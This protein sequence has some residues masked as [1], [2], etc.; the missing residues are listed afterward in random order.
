MTLDTE[1]KGNRKFLSTVI[2]FAVSLTI[3][4]VIYILSIL[5]KNWAM[6]DLIPHEY[7][8]DFVAILPGPLWTDTILLYLFPL[9]IYGLFHL[10]APYI[11]IFF[12]RLH[13]MIY[14]S[15]KRFHYGIIKL[16]TRVKP[17]MLFRRSVIVSLFAFSISALIVQ[18]GFGSLF[19]LGIMEGSALNEAE[20]IFL[21]TFLIISI[22]LLL[23]LPLWL[24]EDSGIVIC[25]LYSDRRRPPLIEGTHAPFVN[26]LQGYAGI[27]TIIILVTYIV[28]TLGESVG[29]SILTP[30]I[31]IVLPFFVTGLISFAVYVYEKNV[32]K[33]IE[34]IQPRLDRLNISE[35]EIPTFDELKR[36]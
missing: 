28:Q 23:F 7:I 9:T 11:T 29:P 16:G 12:L 31:L 32:P 8:I 36:N 14:R 2:G 33:L 34:K 35:I 15:K 10:I 18:A 27:S 26:I 22:V 6:G 5:Q 24:L 30:I 17:F 1:K 25:K 3:F 4:F 13:Q 21:G 20:A 19:R